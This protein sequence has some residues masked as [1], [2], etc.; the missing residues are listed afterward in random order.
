MKWCSIA[1]VR[2]VLD[3]AR[4]RSKQSAV[5]AVI[6]VRDQ[7]R[8]RGFL[9]EVAKK[10]LRRAN[11]YSCVGRALSR[12]IGMFRSLRRGGDQQQLTTRRY[13]FDE[14]YLGLPCRDRARVCIARC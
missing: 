12:K 6:L 11:T 2:I 13:R 5:P 1:I 7:D 14:T 3:L 8:P 9:L 4:C 10:L